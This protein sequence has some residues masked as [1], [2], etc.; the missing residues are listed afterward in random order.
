MPVCSIQLIGKAGL[1]DLSWLVVEHQCSCTESLA[2][3]TS[4][5]CI[6]TPPRDASSLMD[7]LS[8]IDFMRYRTT[9]KNKMGE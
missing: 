6:V 8:A 7:S 5:L 2:V 1:R 3:C 4:K 9:A